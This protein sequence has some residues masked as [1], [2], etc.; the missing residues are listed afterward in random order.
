MAAAAA[1]G[2]PAETAP[3]GSRATYSARM[4]APGGWELMFLLI[5]ALMI[6]GLVRLVKYAIS[7]AQR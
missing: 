3:P 2:R 1:C 4:N 5:F 7:K 6:Y